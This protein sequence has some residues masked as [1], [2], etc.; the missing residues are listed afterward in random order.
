MRHRYFTTPGWSEA[1]REVVRDRP[2]LVWRERLRH[3]TDLIDIAPAET[4]REF[5]VQGDRRLTMGDFR[6][7]VDA[8]ARDLRRRGIASGDRVLLLGHNS[9]EFFLAPWALWRAGAVPVLG[10]RWWSTPEI[11]SVAAAASPAA[12]ITDLADAGDLFEV[13]LISLETVRG[14]WDL[15]VT[16][17]AAAA[18]ADEDEVALILFTAGSTGPPKG[19]QLTHRNLI[20][21]HQNLRV[22]VT[23]SRSDAELPV[24]PQ[25]SL[26][27]TVP[28]FHYGA[29]RGSAGAVAEGSKVLMPEGR[30]NPVAVLELIERERATGW[31]AVPTQYKRVLDHP[32]F[33]KYDLSSLAT[34][35]TGGAMVPRSLVE[36]IPNRFSGAVNGLRV[37][38]GMSEAGTVSIAT[39]AD[40]MARPLTV[41][42]LI[43]NV[44]VR[45]DSPDESG[46][47]ECLIR[48]AQVMTGYLDAKVQP[49]DEDGWY[50]TGDVG[51]FDADGY[52]YIT[53]RKSDMVIRGGE[54]VSCPHVEAVLAQHPRVV[55]A[56][57]FGVPDEE[58]GEA[59]AAVLVIDSPGAATAE[60]MSVFARRR[61]AHFELPSHWVL[62]TEALPTLATGKVDKRRLLGSYLE[63]TARR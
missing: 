54:N 33:A 2:V 14:W 15:E 52:L 43:D 45:I 5:L 50:H 51:H 9:P 19:V 27:F 37:A 38:Y 46:D 36:A 20:A 1:V 62:T 34:P 35:S 29:L 30:F 6:R 56:A 22:M 44:E 63:E 39:G 59:V 16:E 55:E 42:R 40:L 49:I 31:N 61:L 12:V 47:G 8:G 53:G 13:P 24:K 4:A 18:A 21:A 7:A 28:L 11:R 10:N 25:A 23:G 17:T 41:G 57:A 32:E 48:S 60:E 58:F 26:L 3:V